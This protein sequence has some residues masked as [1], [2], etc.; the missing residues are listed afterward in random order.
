VRIDQKVIG[1]AMT[2]NWYQASYLDELGS[3]D[4]VIQSDGRS[5]RTTIRGVVF[6]GPDFD[7]LSIDEAS[8]PAAKDTFRLLHDGILCDCTI[9]L[10]IPASVVVKDLRTLAGTLQVKLE[11]GPPRKCGG[12]ADE[13]PEFERLQL[14]LSFEENQFVSAGQS[15]DFEDALED[16]HRQLP[17]G[18]YLKACYKCLY[19]DY[20]VYGHGLFG[21]MMCFRNAKEEYLS[22]RNKSDFMDIQDLYESIV[23]ETHLCADFRLRVPGTGYRG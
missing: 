18:T 7:R 5:L 6:V 15:G 11:I 23:Q 20:S 12:G 1:F 14:R 22:V 17:D 16:I 4:I 2:I 21:N 13:W 3:E 19:S 10:M 9:T 8:V